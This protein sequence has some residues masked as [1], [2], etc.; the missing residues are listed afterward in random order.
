M[1]MPRRLP[2]GGVSSRIYVRTGPAKA[3]SDSSNVSAMSPHYDVG[4]YSSTGRGSA[5][6][7]STLAGLLM[8]VGILSQPTE[9]YHL[10]CPI[11][12]TVLYWNSLFPFGLHNKEIILVIQKPARCCPMKLCL[13]SSNSSIRARDSTMTGKAI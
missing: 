8:G 4:L 7:P 6:Q 1:M 12:K 9:I 2:Q 5:C 11:K 13:Q 10:M 3:S